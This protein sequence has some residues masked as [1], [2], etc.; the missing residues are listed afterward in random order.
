MPAAGHRDPR[1]PRG[2]SRPAP[3]LLPDLCASAE[4]PPLASTVLPAAPGAQ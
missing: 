3:I 2:L 1:G 4:A